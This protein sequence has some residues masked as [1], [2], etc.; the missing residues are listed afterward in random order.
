MRTW[1]PNITFEV[2]LN[3]PA[4]RLLGH[5]VTSQWSYDVH[6]IDQYVQ[7]RLLNAKAQLLLPNLTDSMWNSRTFQTHSD[8]IPP[9]CHHCIRYPNILWL[10]HSCKSIPNWISLK[11]NWR[12]RAPKDLK[13]EGTRSSFWVRS[14]TNVMGLFTQQCQQ[15]KVKARTFYTQVSGT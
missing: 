5:F 10:L 11:F 3:N 7:A 2:Y 12:F 4:S 15:A 1:I 6:M 14:T 9:Q 13:I 8:M